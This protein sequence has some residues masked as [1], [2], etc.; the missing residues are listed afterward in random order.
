MAYPTC[1]NR[2]RL[3][4]SWRMVSL[5][6]SPKPVQ[7]RQQFWGHQKS[8]PGAGTAENMH[9]VTCHSPVEGVGVPALHAAFCCLWTSNPSLDPQQEV[10]LV[11]LSQPLLRPQHETARRFGSLFWVEDT[12]KAHVWHH[13][14]VSAEN[15][16]QNSLE[17][18][19]CIPIASCM[20]VATVTNSLL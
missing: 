4:L 6:Q 12:R 20:A 3:S 10:K 7:L 8:Q 2:N 1:G 18:L 16:Q 15:L 11:A 14:D 19:V 13:K 5:S 9:F 17:I